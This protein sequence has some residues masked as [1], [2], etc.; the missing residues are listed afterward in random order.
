MKGMGEEGIDA[1]RI[2]LRPGEILVSRKPTIVSTVLGSCVAVTM[3]SPRVRAGAICHATLPERGGASGL[4]PS[5]FVSD[6]VPYMMECFEKL[7]IKRGET[8]VKLFGGADVLDPAG[9][10]YVSATVG[11][12]NIR[13]ALRIVE[14][15]R[16]HLFVYNVGGRLGRKIFFCTH[17]GDILL[18]HIRQQFVEPSMK[19][20]KAL[21]IND[22]AV[23]VKPC[24]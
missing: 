4:A 10:A 22:F 19:K 5:H 3:F 13:R 2:F 6:A 12:Q 21:T 8:E 11:T 16:L 20:T 18:R 17:T 7:G 24:T 23:A 14:E 1:T 9:G 15:E